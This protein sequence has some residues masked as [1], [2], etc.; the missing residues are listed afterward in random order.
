MKEDKKTLDE[1]LAGSFNESKKREDYIVSYKY[2]FGKV[3]ISY[4][5]C[6]N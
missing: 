6:I 3:F 4:D 1:L 2:D 5:F